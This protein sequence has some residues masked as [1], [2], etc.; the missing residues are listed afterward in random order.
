MD[1]IFRR[2]APDVRQWKAANHAGGCGGET[3]AHRSRG[4]DDRSGAGRG[5]KSAHPGAERGH[6]RA[7]AA[8]ESGLRRRNRRSGTGG[9][10]NRRGRDAGAGAGSGY[11]GGD[12]AAEE[13]KSEWHVE[14]EIWLAG[15]PERFRIRSFMKKFPKVDSSRL[16]RRFRGVTRRV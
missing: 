11:R 14:W 12:P 16:S 5:R 15:P 1:R 10:G 13:V 9:K 2:T 8:E 6:H 3:T 7:G 4:A